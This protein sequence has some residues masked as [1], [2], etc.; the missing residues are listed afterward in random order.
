[1]PRVEHIT[2]LVHL[3]RPTPHA[4]TQQPALEANAVG[5]STGGSGHAGG[6]RGTWGGAETTA[7]NLQ[8]PRLARVS[9]RQAQGE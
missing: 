1:N 4:H 8:R 6:W 9:Q 5:G 3:Y 7:Q 2:G